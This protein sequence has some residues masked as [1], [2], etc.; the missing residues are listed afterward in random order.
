TW[1]IRGTLHFVAPS[2]ARWMLKCLTPR[3]M[4]AANKIKSSLTVKK[5]LHSTAVSSSSLN[6]CK[7]RTLRL[8]F[9]APNAERPTPN[10]EPGPRNS[11]P[12][13]PSVLHQ[14]LQPVQDGL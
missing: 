4:A 10:G 8:H 3:S 6:T 1:P 7:A 14:A 2:D 12:L 11:F 13:L 5:Q 9:G